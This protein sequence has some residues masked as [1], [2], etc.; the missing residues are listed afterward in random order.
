MIDSLQHI[1]AAAAG[2]GSQQD[3]QQ[4][5]V[6]LAA[7]SALV[8]QQLGAA[9]G[10]LV[11]CVHEDIPADS[12]WVRYLEHSSEVGRGH[13]LLGLSSRSHVGLP[14]HLSLRLVGWTASCAFA[15]ETAWVG[16]AATPD[17]P[18]VQVVVRLDPV[19]G[20]TAELDGCLTL[21]RRCVH[22]GG[23]TAAPTDPSLLQAGDSRSYF[24]RCG[25]YSVKWLPQ[26]SAHQLL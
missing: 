10:A 12:W 6:F 14:S 15:R 11:W 26:M 23:G 16:V 7:C 22:P 20:R 2:A 5:L 13:Q 24:F 21:Q 1:A 9:T 4:W 3:R 25:E 18:D 19:E 8:Q 17:V